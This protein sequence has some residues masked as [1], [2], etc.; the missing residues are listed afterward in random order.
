M[1][2]AVEKSI[3]R[4]YHRWGLASALLIMIL[5]PQNLC[6]FAVTDIHAQDNMELL[7]TAYTADGT[8]GVFHI[9]DGSNYAATILSIDK[10]TPSVTFS[11]FH[12]SNTTVMNRVDIDQTGDTYITQL[13]ST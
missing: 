10:A 5:V 11:P 4:K 9:S 1:T 12:I 6:S 2:E 13:A 7:E 3:S 8:F